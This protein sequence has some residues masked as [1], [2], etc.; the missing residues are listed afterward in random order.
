[1]RALMISSLDGDAAAYRLLLSEL[2]RH[3]RPYF[4][5][6]LHAAHA[7]DAEDLVQETLMAVHSRRIT[8]DRGKPFTAWLHAVAHHKFVDHVRRHSRR[9]AV[10]LADDMAIFARDENHEIAVRLDMDTMLQAVPE[11][12]GELIRQVKI[13][14]ASIAEAAAATGMSESAVKVSIHRGLK[15]LSARFSR[16]TDDK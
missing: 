1:M 6:R 11:R 14:G 7:A 5:R 9:M 13:D 2:A 3:L 8:Y 12:T 10:P 15:A 4:A 16:K